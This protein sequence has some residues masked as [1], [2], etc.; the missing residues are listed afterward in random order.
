[1]TCPKVFLPKKEHLP[2]ALP[3][4]IQGKVLFLNFLHKFSKAKITNV[5]KNKSPYS[6]VGCAV[7]ALRCENKERKKKK[8]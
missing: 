8:T 1:L 5:N 2:I 7:A 6:G 3:F 4:L